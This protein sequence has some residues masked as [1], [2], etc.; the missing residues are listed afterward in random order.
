MQIGKKLWF[1][2]AATLRNLQIEKI[3]IIFFDKH[4][5]IL[6]TKEI[7]QSKKTE[8][9]FSAHTIFA[10][11]L[12]YGS[13]SLVVIHN[14]PSG[15]AFPSHSDYLTT[16]A[17]SQGAQLLQLKLLDHLIVTKDEY[18]SFREAGIL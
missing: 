17:I 4:Q 6:A 10:P 11:A 7:T 3:L 16:L 5:K 1:K 18:F 9:R 15:S 12:L 2:H 14:H 8:T 13:D